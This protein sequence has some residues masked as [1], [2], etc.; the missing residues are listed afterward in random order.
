M[1]ERMVL[2]MSGGLG[3]F[4]RQR[5][6]LQGDLWHA[7]IPSLSLQ[8]N[9]CRRSRGRGFCV[10]TM[11]RPGS[12]PSCLSTHPGSRQVLCVETSLWVAALSFAPVLWPRGRL[13]LALHDPLTDSQTGR[14][15]PCILAEA[16]VLSE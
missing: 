13:L 2:Q 14:P 5:V 7:W 15:P 1:A 6:C 4:A 11:R 10:S 16:V 3:T 12:F 9:C 8:V